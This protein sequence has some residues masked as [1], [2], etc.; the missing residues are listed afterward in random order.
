MLFHEVQNNHLFHIFTNFLVTVYRTKLKN[1][2][3]NIVIYVL[4]LIVLFT[5]VDGNISI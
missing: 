1:V 4:H 3:L 2:K 5:I